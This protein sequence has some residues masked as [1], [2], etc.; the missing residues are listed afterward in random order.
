[1]IDRKFAPK[2]QNLRAPTLVFADPCGYKGLSLQLVTSALKGF[3][4]DC[5]FFFNYNRVNMK[6]S[7]PVM[8]GSIDEFFEKHRA[9][10]LRTE[11]Q[12]LSPAKR[13]ERVL[14]A[15][16][17][18]IHQQGGV[19]LVFPFRTREGGG[20]SHHLVFASKG[21]KGVTIMKRIMNKASSSIDHGV[22]SFDFDP[23]DDSSAGRLFSSLEEVRAR[24]LSV[25]AGREVTFKQIIAEELRET[26]FIE[27]NYRDALLE[28][29]HAGRVRV[30]PSAEDRRW[31]EAG[32][33]RTLP[34]ATKIIFP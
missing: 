29:E 34:L 25:F 6:L 32:V 17:A 4:N 13:E 15:I 10:A 16:R 30:T 19:P 28:L 27:S 26:N 8:D 1:V 5:I 24:L 23:R 18:A 22:G 11:I 3:G 14:D 21:E 12:G 33:K 9:T 7:Y 31:H 20:T 2:L